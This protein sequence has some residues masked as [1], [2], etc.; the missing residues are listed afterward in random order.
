[1]TQSIIHTQR[2]FTYNILIS[3]VMFPGFHLGVPAEEEV[4]IYT[5]NNYCMGAYSPRVCMLHVHIHVHVLVGR[6]TYDCVLRKVMIS[7]CHSPLVKNYGLRGLGFQA[8]TV[9]MFHQMYISQ[10]L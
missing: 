8:C 4:H 3:L 5:K 6:L 7:K 2:M 10:S 9:H 1:M